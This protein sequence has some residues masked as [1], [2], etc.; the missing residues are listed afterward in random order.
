V[1][2]K[3]VRIDDAIGSEISYVDHPANSMATIE[4]V[5]IAKKAEMELNPDALKAIG[6]T[7][8]EAGFLKRLLGLF[9]KKDKEPYGDVAYA[10]S[11]HQSD[12]K[13]RYPID[14]EAH[15]R[16]AWSYINQKK[17]ADKYD[18]K[19]L[20]EIKGKIRAAAKKFGIEI[21]D[22]KAAQADDLRKSLYDVGR[23]AELVCALDYMAQSA[24]YER[25][26]EGDESLMPEKLLQSRDTLGELLIEM[27]SEEVG[28]LRDFMGAEK[29]TK[30]D[31]AAAITKA[32]KEGKPAGVEKAG[33]KMSA[34]N[35]EHFTKMK[36][37]MASAGDYF[38]KASKDH[39]DDENLAQGMTH[40]MAAMQYCQ[41]MDVG[42]ESEETESPESGDIEEHPGGKSANVK[43]LVKAAVAEATGEFRKELDTIK[44]ELEKTKEEK[45]KL[46]IENAKLTE[47]TAI[48]GKMPTAPRS[49]VS[50]VVKGQDAPAGGRD[51]STIK[52]GDLDP[53][54]PD[55]LRKGL[56]A[57]Y[58]APRVMHRGE[59]AAN[60]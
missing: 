41:K 35:H 24:E 16:A 7:P 54:A 12:G 51:D 5:V 25:Q 39:P 18:A 48:L 37:H 29:M 28:E 40:H 32:L 17:N 44:G 8:E 11:G 33:R 6:A 45:H 26:S 42:D 49:I 53:K 31:L 13:K 14:T 50:A 10:D 23:L 34:A 46:E 55:S 47:R 52:I 22:E 38:G 57:V 9:S 43:T 15:V 60:T 2:R 59:F 30:E 27:V 56:T 4:Q 1:I 20:A 21:A 36:K 19:A 58:A 3:A